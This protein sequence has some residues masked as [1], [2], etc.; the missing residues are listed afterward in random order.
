[1]LQNYLLI[2]ADKGSTGV[3][4]FLDDLYTDRDLR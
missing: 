1:M 4:D 2:T 3:L